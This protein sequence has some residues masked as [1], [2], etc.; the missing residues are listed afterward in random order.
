MHTHKHAHG[1][2]ITVS[3]QSKK[4]FIKEIHQRYQ[5][6][7]L[8]LKPTRKFLTPAESEHHVDI[9]HKHHQISRTPRL[10]LRLS[11][12]SH[13]A[14]EASPPVCLPALSKV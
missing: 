6:T 4:A 12:C 1:V 11:D 14:T 2:K 7:S 10:G 8:L 5:T 13:T 3:H 9:Q